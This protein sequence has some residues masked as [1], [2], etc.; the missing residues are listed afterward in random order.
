ML[1]LGPGDRG[2]APSH[3]IRRPWQ[4]TAP[5]K[6]NAANATGDTGRLYIP[7]SSVLDNGN[8]VEV[9]RSHHQIDGQ[10]PANHENHQ[11]QQRS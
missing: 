7:E 6:L 9:F 4:R 11:R 2:I 8:R 10:L 5:N 3:V 1:A